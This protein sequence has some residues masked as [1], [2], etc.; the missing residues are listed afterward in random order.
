MLL[1]GAVEI[2]TERRER[3]ELA[4]LGK[5]DTQPTGH[6]LHCPRLSRATD[7]RHRDADV[8]G[9]AHTGVEQV[10]LQEALAV[11]DRDDVRRDVGGDVVALGLDDRQAG[12][13]AT[14]QLVGQLRA[15]LEQPRVQVEHV[16]G[17]GLATWRAAQQQRDRAVGLGLLGQVVEHDQDVLA[18]VHPVLADRRAG[19][20]RDVLE[21]RSVR[22][23]RGDDRRVLQCAGLVER[24]P[25]RR[26]RRTL[27][28]DRDVDAAHLLLHVA[29][30]PVVALVDD[31]V[32][33]DRRLAG[34]PVADDQLPLTASDG[35]HRVDG[36][37]AG[38]QR[39]LD[40]LALHDAGRLQFERASL[41]GRD[42]AQAVD[43]GAERVDH[44]A[45]VTVTDRHGEHLT[46]PLDRL[47]LFDLRGVTQDHHADVAD[48]EVQRDAQRAAFEL[49]Q[50]VRHRTGQALDRGDPVA[51]RGHDADLLA[52]CRRRVGRHEALDSAADLVRGD[53]QLSHQIFPISFID[54]MVNGPVLP[55][56]QRNA[57]PASHR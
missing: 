5:I 18:R 50:L 10:G 44:A 21:A 4:V 41:V 7:T 22:G 39:L 37:D 24:L 15:A 30:L 20:G 31:R 38:E 52:R 19:V 3:L 42:L 29:A 46:G 1:A 8:D 32:D 34:L 48:V 35:R 55:W 47:A 51:R 26:D 43:R 57:M 17:V 54:L 11:G 33:A 2:G 56:Q 27:L 25:D 28:A 16:A 9:R 12:H 49:E 36:L 6:V 45:Q 14:T 13:R 53:R 40:V 23:R